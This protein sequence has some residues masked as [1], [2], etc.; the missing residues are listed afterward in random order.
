MKYIRATPVNAVLWSGNNLSE[1]LHFCRKI[2]D[3]LYKHSDGY[4]CLDGVRVDP[5]YYIV[6]S[7]VNNDH[8]V[9]VPRTEFEAIHI[10]KDELIRQ[11]EDSEIVNGIINWLSKEGSVFLVDNSGDY[12]KLQTPTSILLDAMKLVQA[13]SNEHR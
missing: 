13:I 12:K 7:W 1:V 4:L 11:F 9:I 5:D 6:E 3:T 2:K 8:Y 10:E